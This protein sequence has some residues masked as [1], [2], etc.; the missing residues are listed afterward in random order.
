MI[1]LR[2][3]KRF[4]RHH[5]EFPMA[6]PSKSTPGTRGRVLCHRGTHICSGVVFAPPA[7]DDLESD[8][9]SDPPHTTHATHTQDPPNPASKPRSRNEP[10]LCKMTKMPKNPWV[11]IRFGGNDLCRS[12]RQF[13][14]HEGDGPENHDR[15]A[16][17]PCSS[18][19][20]E[21]KAKGEGFQR[22]NRR[23]RSLHFLLVF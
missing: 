12:A 6:I 1:S 14:H 11:C 17:L 2:R 22:E 8:L 5:E 13:W 20:E 3:P 21:P 23:V 18:K 19:A 7:V 9:R 15:P 10:K 4:P 16:T